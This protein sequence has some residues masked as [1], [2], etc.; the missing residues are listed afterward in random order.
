MNA[1]TKLHVHTTEYGEMI[2]VQVQKF[3]STLFCW[4]DGQKCGD[5]EI[6]LNQRKEK[7]T[8]SNIGK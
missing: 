6:N 7:K 3:Y 2:S 4:L 5:I 8:G 1:V